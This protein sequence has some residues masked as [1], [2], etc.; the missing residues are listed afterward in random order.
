[1]KYFKK[2]SNGSVYRTE[3]T[4]FNTGEPTTRLQRFNWDMWDWGG[5]IHDHEDTRRRINTGDGIIE[6]TEEEAIKLTSK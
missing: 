1:M 6:I 4:H 2:I 5:H 3:E